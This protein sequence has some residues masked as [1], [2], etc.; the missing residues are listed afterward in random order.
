[1]SSTIF[2]RRVEAR[3][4]ILVFLCQTAWQYFD[5]DPHPLTGASNAGTVGRNR[6]RPSVRN[7]PIS[8]ENGITYGHSF[9][10]RTVVQSF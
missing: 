7:V 1:M 10:H 5:E 6:V 8:D 2:H 9:L 3:A 4:I